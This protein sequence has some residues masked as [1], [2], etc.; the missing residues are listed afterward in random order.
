[1]NQR[2]EKTFPIPADKRMTH[3]EW[4]LL[5]AILANPVECVRIF[6]VLSLKPD[7]EVLGPL[8]SYVVNEVGTASAVGL[9]SGMLVLWIVVPMMVSV[10][11]ARNQDA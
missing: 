4:K 3:Q 1:M 9:L 2:E 7:L 6:F 10:L 11:I 5:I 8:G